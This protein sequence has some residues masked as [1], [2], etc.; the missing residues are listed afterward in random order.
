MEE[1]QDLKV[2]QNMCLFPFEK[3]YGN[4]THQHQNSD[5]YEGRDADLGLWLCL[6]YIFD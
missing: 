3:N 2:C 5:V 4:I 1:N 6:F